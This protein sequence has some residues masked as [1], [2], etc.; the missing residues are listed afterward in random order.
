MSLGIGNTR[1]WFPDEYKKGSQNG[2]AN[3]VSRHTVVA[4][5]HAGQ[6]LDNMQKAQR[7]D[8][9][10]SMIYATLL[11]KKALPHSGQWRQHPI[12]TWW[13]LW[14]VD[15][16]LKL[17]L[18]CYF[19]ANAS[20]KE[21][22]QRNHDTPSAGHQGVEKKLK[23]KQEA[24]LVHMEIYTSKCLVCE[25][26]KYPTLTPAPLTNLTNWQTKEDN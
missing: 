8:P 2:N 15:S 18:W 10:I 3:A 4:I 12:R 21:A 20:G 24:F 19:S 16:M 25:Q 7:D 17:S 23:L 5:T 22:L 13:T 6:P 14:Y 9:A 11:S 1:V 26:T